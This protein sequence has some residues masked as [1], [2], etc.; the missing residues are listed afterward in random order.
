ML[1]SGSEKDRVDAAGLGNDFRNLLSNGLDKDTLFSSSVLTLSIHLNFCL[2]SNSQNSN[3]HTNN[4]VPCLC[5]EEFVHLCRQWLDLDYSCLHYNLAE[6]QPVIHL[7]QSLQYLETP[8]NSRCILHC[9]QEKLLP[10]AATSSIVYFCFLH[11]T[12]P[13]PVPH[14]HY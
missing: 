9:F 5:G 2:T 4:F 13:I 8:A 3:S 11:P 7:A 14:I 12:H 6:P 10:S 1:K